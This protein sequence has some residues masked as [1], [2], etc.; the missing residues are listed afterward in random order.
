MAYAMKHDSQITVTS[1]LDMIVGS[2]LFL[3][4]GFV[5]SL[6]H[7]TA[8]IVSC[9]CVGVIVAVLAGFHMSKPVRVKWASWVNV[10]LGFW[11]IVSPFVLGFYGM[12]GGTWTAVI[13]GLLVIFLAGWSSLA[14]REYDVR[15]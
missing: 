1:G 14:A 10:V 5:P 6:R 12:N 11:L 3:S 7:S 13:V 9:M 15:D 8:A 2:W 4:P